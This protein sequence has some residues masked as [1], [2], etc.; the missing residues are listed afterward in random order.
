MKLTLIILAIIFISGYLIKMV[1][2]KKQ[3]VFNG[4]VNKRVSFEIVK[5]ELSYIVFDDLKC[6]KCGVKGCDLYWFSFRTSNA[7]WRQLAGCIGFY[8]K[9]P[10]CKIVVDNY[11]T[12]M[13]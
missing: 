5:Q 12:A 11:I 7:S 4:S 1:V 6:T 10:K 13:N 2:F 9:C 3:S 8:C